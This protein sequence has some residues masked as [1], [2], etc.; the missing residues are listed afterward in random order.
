MCE[1]HPANQYTCYTGVSGVNLVSFTCGVFSHVYETISTG[2]TLCIIGV[3]YTN[4]T[5]VV[6]HMLYTR[7]FGVIL[8]S[9]HWLLV[10]ITCEMACVIHMFSR[11]CYILVLCVL[12]TNRRYIFRVMLTRVMHVLRH[13]C[14]VRVFCELISIRKCTFRVHFTH[15]IHVICHTCNIRGRYVS[16]GF[17]AEKTGC[18]L[19]VS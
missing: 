2:F 13:T 15:V 5:R 16:I 14:N 6:V 19:W 1:P 17:L 4:I 11:M 9:F 7:F 10:Y 18:K 3:A 12:V 8:A